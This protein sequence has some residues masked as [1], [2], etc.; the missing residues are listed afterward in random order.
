VT[1]AG[2]GATVR[3]TALK[4][5]DVS[6]SGTTDAS[7][8]GLSG[9]LQISSLDYNS[10]SAGFARLHWAKAFDLDGD[11]TADVLDPGALLP[12]LMAVIAFRIRRYGAWVTPSVSRAS[13]SADP[14]TSA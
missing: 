14:A 12:T 8:F 10:V 9:T 6:V 2:Q 5:S 13:G 7:A 11:G 1:P 4:L 3:Y